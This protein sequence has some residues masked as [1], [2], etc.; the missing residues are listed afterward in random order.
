MNR[1]GLNLQQQPG[2]IIGGTAMSD[3]YIGNANAGQACVAEQQRQD[4]TVHV[5]VELK[6]TRN[7]ADALMSAMAGY[8]VT[9]AGWNA[10][11]QY[12]EAQ[13]PDKSSRMGAPYLVLKN[14]LGVLVPWVP[15]QGDLFANDW[16]FL[17]R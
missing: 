7:F 10:G 16:A 5:T 9:R 3:G 13:F 1:S 12:V 14:S 11:G 17:P 6:A 8:R 2:G 15:S 4:P